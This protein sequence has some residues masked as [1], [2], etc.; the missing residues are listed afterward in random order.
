MS[1][2]V[3]EYNGVRTSK[4]MAQGIG[5]AGPLVE[6]I[7]G[8]ATDSYCSRSFPFSRHHAN[9]HKTCLHKGPTLTCHHGYTLFIKATLLKKTPWSP[10]RSSSIE[11]PTAQHD[12]KGFFVTRLVS[13][14]GTHLHGRSFKCQLY[15]HRSSAPS[16]TPGCLLQQHHNESHHGQLA[17]LLA[18]ATPNYK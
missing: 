2:G 7:A 1:T 8:C 5:Q 18:S 14:K 9:I 12:R 11:N 16:T 4:V 17:S 13:L 3:I 6:V 10:Q 15:P